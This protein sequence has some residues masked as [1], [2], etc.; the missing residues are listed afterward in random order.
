MDCRAFTQL[1]GQTKMP[2]SALDA[3]FFDSVV[4]TAAERPKPISQGEIATELAK[5]KADPFYF[6]ETYCWI[7]DSVRADWMLFDLWDSQ[8]RALQAVIDSKYTVTLK[9]RQLGLTW[10]LGD[11]YVLWHML[12]K[13]IAVVLI[14]SQGKDEAKE[15]LERIKDT[16]KLLPDWMKLDLLVDNTTD[17]KLPNKS[18]V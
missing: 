6:I 18:G 13:P 15:L 8:K 14:F 11:A 17:F 3:A 10:L 16:Y 7:Y 4:A 1:N 9:A 5:C 12:F 2:E